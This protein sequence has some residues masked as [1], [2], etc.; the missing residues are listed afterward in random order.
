M[1][2]LA[3]GAHWDDVE[4]GCCLTL[5]KLSKQ[6]HKVYC[7]VLCSS[8][9]T[10]GEHHGPTEDEAQERGLQSFELFGAEYIKTEKKENSR[11]I[12]DKDV[13]QQLEKVAEE[14]EINAVFCH[15]FGDLNTDHQATWK[16]ART[17]FRRT[18]NFLMYQSNS[19]TDNVDRFTPN[20][21]HG[22]SKEEY[23]L[24]TKILETHVGEW[25]YRQSRWEREIFD[26]ERFWGY[27]CGQEYAEGFML[28]KVV[29]NSF[30][31]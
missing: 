20:Y 27:S 12:Y 3:V 18:E 23:S 30:P 11:L 8:H 19:Y 22:F 10:V 6:G 7:V 24:K 14:Y 4:L 13:M 2:I 17:A 9:Y 15:W 25:A 29:N 31:S 21:F 5:K 16:I 26:R 28:G 1:N